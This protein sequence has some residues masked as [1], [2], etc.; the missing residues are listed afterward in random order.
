MVKTL[1]KEK[2]KQ[3]S[4]PIIPKQIKK[5]DLKK[6]NWMELFLQSFLN[7][8]VDELVYKQWGFKGTD[9][10]FREKSSFYN[11]IDFRRNQYRD[12]DLSELTEEEFLSLLDQNI[13]LNSYTKHIDSENRILN[14]R[15]MQ[16]YGTKHQ[17]SYTPVLHQCK[18]IEEAKIILLQ[19]FNA[20]K[21]DKRSRRSFKIG[22][23][24]YNRDNL[25]KYLPEQKIA[26][27]NSTHSQ[28]QLQESR[29]PMLMLLQERLNSLPFRLVDINTV[30]VLDRGKQESHMVYDTSIR[31]WDHETNK[32]TQEL[33]LI[34]RHFAGTL[35][36]INDKRYYLMDLDRVE[37]EH[38]ILNIFVVELPYPVKTIQEAYN[39]LI[40]EEVSIA[41]EF[42]KKVIRSGEFFFIPEEIEINLTEEDL[43]IKDIIE[44][45][46]LK[47]ET[48]YSGNYL[49]PYHTQHLSDILVRLNPDKEKELAEYYKS[50]YHYDHINSYKK[51]L[52]EKNIDLLTMRQILDTVNKLP[53]PKE[54]RLAD[55][56]P[57]CVDE[58]VR[59]NKTTYARGWVKNHQTH[60]HPAYGEHQFIFL[61]TWHKVIPNRAP[62]MMKVTGQID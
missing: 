21:K 23:Q 17:P 55:N 8:N 16:P 18:D 1:K 13:F 41:K 3:K 5:E 9:L 56:S 57:I 2:T 27:F 62:S 10:F 22:C 29:S 32:Y 6:G 19:Y 31:Q 53:L 30:K 15:I 54:I 48:V 34:L 7:Q 45:I 33:P 37:I 61:D 50:D 28:R 4:L 42:D 51:W 40:P 25:V 58:S 59:I 43:R 38:K 39:S 47:R 24:C 44:N 35:L 36:Y 49:N 52:V 60:V 11:V 12:F 46:W 20:W 14:I 26:V